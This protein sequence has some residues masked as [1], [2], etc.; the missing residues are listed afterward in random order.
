MVQF[1]FV[2]LADSG[3]AGPQRAMQ[4]TCRSEG[5]LSLAGFDPSRTYMHRTGEPESGRSELG[6]LS[7]G[8]RHLP[9]YWSAAFFVRGC[10]GDLAPER[11]AS[12]E[13]TSCLP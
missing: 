3:P 12:V 5:V 11:N 7:I 6:G 9:V 8:R 4:E 10:L 2:K 13:I 1:A